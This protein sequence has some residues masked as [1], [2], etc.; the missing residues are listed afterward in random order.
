MQVNSNINAMIQL[1]KK[2][3]QSTNALAKMNTN[4]G[5]PNTKQQKDIKQQ[6]HQSTDDGQKD[7]DLS[8]EIISNME[9]PLA[10]GVN[11]NVVSVQN[12]VHQTTLDI[13]A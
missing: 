12:A 3:E 13:K 9:M 1:E 11:G 7:Q 5:E 2:L 8:K 4:S 6:F 10:Y